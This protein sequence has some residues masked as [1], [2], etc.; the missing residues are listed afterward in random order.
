MTRFA[1]APWPL[2]AAYVGG[3]AAA[4]A[5]LLLGLAAVVALA[6]LKRLSADIDP[7]AVPA[8]FWYFRGDPEVRRH[9]DARLRQLAAD[10]RTDPAMLARGEELKAELLVATSAAN[11]AVVQTLDNLTTA[12]ADGKI[13]F[14]PRTRNRQLASLIHQAINQIGANTQR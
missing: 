14:D 9:L 7:A 12:P 13:A 2:K 3:L 8:W 1:S 6:G 5:S 10:L 4:A 11:L